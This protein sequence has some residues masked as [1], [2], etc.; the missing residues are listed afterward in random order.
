MLKPVKK[1]H[2]VKFDKE[3]EYKMQLPGSLVGKH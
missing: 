1:L 2:P 3:A